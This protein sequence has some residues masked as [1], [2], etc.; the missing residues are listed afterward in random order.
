[1]CYNVKYNPFKSYTEILY[2]R[3]KIL[4]QSYECKIFSISEVETD[5]NVLC[6][7]VCQFISFVYKR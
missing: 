2:N 7:G 6:L 1:M 4:D 5:Y 3:L